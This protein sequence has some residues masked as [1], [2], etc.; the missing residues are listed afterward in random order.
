MRVQPGDRVL[1]NVAPFIGSRIRHKDSI[2]CEVLATDGEQVQVRTE[3][4]YRTFSLWID[5]RWID[6]PSKPQRELALSAN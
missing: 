3:L 2:P 1:V 5:S 4:P 6:V